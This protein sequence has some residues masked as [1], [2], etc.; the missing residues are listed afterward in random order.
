MAGLNFFDKMFDFDHDGKLG[1]LEQG[2]KWGTL[3][4]MMDESSKTS[5]SV[6]SSAVNSAGPY[7]SGLD[8][9]QQL[10]LELAGLDTDELEY[11]D[12]EE[13]R[14]ALEDAGL[15]PDDYDFY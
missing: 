13:R 8:D 11:M 2:V 5:A 6:H 10:D 7:H 3:A 12:E 9:M 15:D 14:E 1:A 4:H